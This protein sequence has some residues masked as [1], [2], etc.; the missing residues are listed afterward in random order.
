VRLLLPPGVFRPPSDAHLLASVL[1]PHAPGADVLDLCTG[2]GVLAVAAARH[3]ARSVTAVDISRR[4]VATARVNGRLNG[5]RIA[6]R[7]GDLYAAVPGERFDLI[8]ANPPYIPAA[9]PHPPGRGPKRALDAGLDGRLF[10]DRVLDGAREHLRPGGV[11]LVVHSS[12]NGVEASLERLRRRGL[13]A[14][15]AAS[16]RG[17]LGPVVSG[18]AMLLEARGLLAPGQRHEDMVVIRGRRTYARV[19]RVVSQPVGV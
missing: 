14:D 8:L 18:R 7:R 15:V 1:C 10:V 3:G 11:V 12:F 5:R 19:S 13:E 16:R 2:S 9:T 6:A 4:A 17:P